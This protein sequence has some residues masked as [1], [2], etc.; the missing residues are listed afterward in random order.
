MGAHGFMRTPDGDLRRFDGATA[1]ANSQTR[2]SALRLLQQGN[3]RIGAGRSQTHRA[4]AHRSKVRDSLGD[5][6]G[7]TANPGARERGVTFLGEPSS[8]KDKPRLPS[9]RSRASWTGLHPVPRLRRPGPRLRPAGLR[10]VGCARRATL[11]GQRRSV[12]VLDD[13][14]HRRRLKAS[15]PSVPGRPMSREGHATA[16]APPGN[17]PDA[18]R[19]LP[20]QRM[21]EDDGRRGPRSPRRSH[22]AAGD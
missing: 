21:Q 7:L 12:Q 8:R 14:D 13:L 11:A 4:E 3:D 19:D 2:L 20:L 15:E 9:A 17:R 18:C 10:C 22:P 5:Q 16:S 1:C 6:P